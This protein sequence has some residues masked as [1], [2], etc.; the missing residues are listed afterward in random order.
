MR[1]KRVVTIGVLNYE[2]KQ[3]CHSYNLRVSSPKQHNSYRKSLRELPTLRD[4]A[5][6]T[7]SSAGQRACATSTTPII[8]GTGLRQ[9]YPDLVHALH[10]S[11]H[12]SV[13]A[14]SRRR[15]QRTV[16]QY[17]RQG[18]RGHYMPGQRGHISLQDRLPVPAGDSDDYA[19]LPVF[20]HFPG[21]VTVIRNRGLIGLL[22]YGRLIDPGSFRRIPPRLLSDAV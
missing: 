1:L 13:K 19:S 4:F 17:N 11:H 2:T 8:T 3:D 12:L 18:L 10:I 16:L 9:R 14:G 15:V 5:F 6:F 22:I 21:L 7:C 20:D